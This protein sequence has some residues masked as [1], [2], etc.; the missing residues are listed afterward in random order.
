MVFDIDSIINHYPVLVV[1]KHANY[2]LEK[3]HLASSEINLDDTLK[4]D[5]L[6]YQQNLACIDHVSMTLKNLAIK[7]DIICRTDLAQAKLDNRLI[8]SIG[9]DGTLLDIS[10][11][12]L[13]N[14]ILSVNSDPKR[15]IGALCSCD[16][17]SFVKIM[18]QIIKK[19]IAP[20]PLS[21]L[22]IKISHKILPILALND[23]LFCH[24]NPAFLSRFSLYINQEKCHIKSSGLWIAT[25]AGS[26]GG[27]FSAGAQPI[28]LNK[29]AA[30]IRVREP[31]KLSHASLLNNVITT[32][33][34]CTLECDMND[35]AIFIDGPHKIYDIGF[36]DNIDI[37]FA[38]KPLW[39]FITKE[40]QEKR[41][42][43]MKSRRKLMRILS[44]GG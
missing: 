18:T 15:S 38:D 8:I 28:D 27:I 30:I 44:K 14:V 9:G 24:K 43:M 12:C 25:A 6:A 5:F 13:D 31:L 32:N 39:L 35:A 7:Y 41:Q 21:R 11:Y 17:T 3:N 40:M 2:E 1:Y 19:N 42:N 23:I 36:K 29:K 37:S 4:N 10:H 33:N 16:Q 26:T 22:A 34:I 20:M